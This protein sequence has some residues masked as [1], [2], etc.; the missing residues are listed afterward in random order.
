MNDLYE[1][2]ILLW[3]EHQA[4]LLRRIA[5]GEPVNE[6]PDWA[7]IIEEVESV[8]RSDLRAV[9]SLLLQTLLHTLK[10]KAWPSSPYVCAWEAEARLFRAQAR[11]AFSPVMQQRLD[12]ARIYADAL[13][14]MPT[15]I[16]GQPPQAV[17]PTCPT[18]LDELFGG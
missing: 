18:T 5:A 7:N 1:A 16:D 4:E 6:R 9:Q 10:A 17:P 12:L 2:D 14:A 8:G 13:D 3:S 11:N 15:S